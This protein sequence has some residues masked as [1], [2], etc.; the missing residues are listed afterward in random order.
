MFCGSWGACGVMV[1]LDGGGD[2]DGID[3][4]RMMLICRHDD[5]VHDHEV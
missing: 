2:G 3:G 4:E 5:A 1:V